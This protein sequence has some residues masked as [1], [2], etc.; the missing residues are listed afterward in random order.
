MKKRQVRICLTTNSAS[1]QAQLSFL[2]K[3]LGRKKF[4]E[5][6]DELARSLAEIVK[7]EAISNLN[8]RV[9][10]ASTGNLASSIDVDGK[11]KHY[12]VSG[13]YYLQYAEFGTGVVG[14]ETP[15]PDASADGWIYDI[16]GHGDDGWVYFSDGNYY[17]TLGQQGKLFMYDAVKVAI[18]SIDAEIK[19]IF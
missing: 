3:M 8:A 12:S 16:N 11:D 7:N 13:D 9:G 17:H 5:K 6:A 18:D 14:L 4:E 2:Q 15:H 19:R 10:N 1:V